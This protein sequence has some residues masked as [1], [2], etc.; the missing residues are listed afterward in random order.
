MASARPQS[1]PAA[2][3][4]RE[5]TFVYHATQKTIR[6][7]TTLERAVARE[8]QEERE[9]QEKVP[10]KK[11]GLIGRS[12]RRASTA[13]RS[14]DGPGGRIEPGEGPIA[15][16]DNDPDN[17]RVEYRS[18]LLHDAAAAGDAVEVER[19][20]ETPDGPRHMHQQDLRGWVPLHYAALVDDDCLI[21]I[22]VPRK[23]VQNA[24]RAERGEEELREAEAATGHA[25]GSVA[26]WSTAVYL[27]LRRA[28]IAEQWGDVKL[29]TVTYEGP[30]MLDGDVLTGTAFECFHVSCQPVRLAQLSPAQPE[31]GARQTQ[32]DIMAL[33]SATLEAARKNAA[34]PGTAGGVVLSD[35]LQLEMMSAHRGVRSMHVELATRMVAYVTEQGRSYQAQL[36]RA[37]PAH[38][39]A[40][41]GGLERRGSRGTGPNLARRGTGTL[42]ADYGADAD[43]SIDPVLYGSRARVLRTRD[44]LRCVHALIDKR[45]DVNARD[46]VKATALHKACANGRLTVAAALLLRGADI[47]AADVYGDTSL[48]RVAWNGRLPC[49]R[50]LLEH[51]CPVDI[52]NHTGDT[53]LH[54]AALTGD[55]NMMR[56]LLE[57][58]ASI[59]RRNALGM[60]CLHC[61]V[62]GGNR[63]AI[64]A[65][66]A[67]Y[68]DRGL[69][70]KDAVT[71]LNADTPIHVAVRAGH[72]G[73]IDWLCTKGA[74][75][76][77]PRAPRQARH[78][79][80]AAPGSTSAAR[81]RCSPV[82]TRPSAA[83]ASPRRAH[84]RRLWQ[85]FGARQQVR[86]HARENGRAARVQVEG[87][88][89]GQAGEGEEGGQGGEEG[90]ARAAAAEAEAARGDAARGRRRR[91]AAA[92]GLQARVAARLGAA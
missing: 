58:G 67:M 38:P 15:Q 55:L 50:L 13:R 34:S 52:S 25:S 31:K 40:S 45:A 33:S 70:W 24:A 89:E 11:S 27:A 26:E 59:V 56:V 28:C 5:R 88:R 18:S 21:E 83:R 2:S 90:G 20:L 91:R 61:A 35:D 51:G 77:P 76:T 3:G 41:R 84:A 8:L 86:R 36:P 32:L 80:A 74:L 44:S 81:A 92:L 69:L 7:E 78:L 64:E 68:V 10:E 54:Y 42:E 9:R 53:G 65:V 39:T 63:T 79:A 85:I 6:E 48:H 16:R 30:K 57:R 66:K 4:V 22:M 29:I 37:E 72:L 73:L 46:L 17:I 47:E 1:A 12:H 87:Q 43:L 82:A 62:R 60:S 14:G 19:L 23:S 71:T 75:S 49:A